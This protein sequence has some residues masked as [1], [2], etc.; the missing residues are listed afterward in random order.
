MRILAAY[1]G[2]PCSDVAIDEVVHRPWPAGTELKIVTVVNP[3]PA[4]GS[5]AWALPPRYYDD[6]AKAARER[7]ERVLEEARKRVA[8]HEEG[9]EVTSEVIAGPPALAL[10]DEAERWGADLVVA[11]SHGYGAMKRFLLGSVS[12]ALALHA[13]CSV[14]VVRKH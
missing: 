4:V 14:E 10:V 9:L 5:E 7:G 1:D 6:V 3:W 13:P 8:G 12:H 11:G 2:S